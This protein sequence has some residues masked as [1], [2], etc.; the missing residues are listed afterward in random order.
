[1]EE[2]NVRIIKLPAMRVVSFHAFSKS[3]ET[4]AWVKLAAW[5]K[6]HDCWQEAPAR[7]IFG[8]NNPDP[9]PGSPNYGYEF[10]LTINN[11]FEENNGIKIIDFPGGLYAVMNCD[12]SGDPWEIIPATWG[13][14]V[15]W[16]E[17]GHYKHGNH[18]WLEE[19]LSRGDMDDQGFILD[20]YLP[21]VE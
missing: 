13:K 7:R 5:A 6:A 11:D 16:L 17:S 18:Q 14:L 3:P 1:M 21:I 19:H 8:F 4:D 12:V 15:K 10:W 9:S 2:Q 20:L